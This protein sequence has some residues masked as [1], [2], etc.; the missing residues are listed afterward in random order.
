MLS[1][2]NT[3]VHEGL[4]LPFKFLGGFGLSTKQIGFILTFQG[5]YSM[6]ATLFVFPFV[7]KRLGAINLF[8]CL[9]FGY[10]LLYLITP[11]MILLPDSLRSAALYPMLIWK[12]TFSNL[13]YPACAILLA[14][15]APSLLL[16]GVINGAAASTASLNRALGPTISGFIYSTGQSWGYSGMAWWCSAV[17]AILGAVISVCMSGKCN[18]DDMHDEVVDD[19]ES[20]VDSRQ[21]D[22]S[23]DASRW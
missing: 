5:F 13:A 2:P 15:S 1:T 10:P 23:D 19:E 9:A 17:I 4:A 14:N 3:D 6:V 16:L 12:C 7:V 21:A 20:L 18:R 11:Y 22:E 8:R